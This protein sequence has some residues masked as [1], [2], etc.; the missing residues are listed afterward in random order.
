MI[1]SPRKEVHTEPAITVVHV[2]WGPSK[3][4]RVSY[5]VLILET[6]KMQNLKVMDGSFS[7][8]QFITVVPICV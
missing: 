8:G 7:C 3:L 4:G 1:S 5:V 6:R 2:W